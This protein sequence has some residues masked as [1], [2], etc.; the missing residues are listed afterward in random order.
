MYADL[1]QARSRAVFSLYSIMSTQL[2]YSWGKGPFHVRAGPPDFFYF[3]S[4]SFMLNNFNG[5]FGY[6]QKVVWWRILFLWSMSNKRVLH[7]RKFH[8]GKL[9][10]FPPRF[11]DVTCTVFLGIYHPSKSPRLL[12]SHSKIY[13]KNIYLIVTWKITYLVIYLNP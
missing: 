1:T 4:L 12:Y 2:N 3:P 7:S 11:R 10:L 5:R 6:M 8:S 13:S 9:T